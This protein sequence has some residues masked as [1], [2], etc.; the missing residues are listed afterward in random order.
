MSDDLFKD[1]S[2][3]EE[4]APLFK[5]WNWWYALVIGLLAV[6]VVFFYIITKMFE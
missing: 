6:L 4:P 2:E 1:E 3:M 5:N